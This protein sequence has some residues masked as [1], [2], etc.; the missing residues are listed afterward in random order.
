[1]DSTSIEHCEVCSKEFELRLHEVSTNLYTKTCPE[2][3]E[4]GTWF[5]AWLA[6][7]AAGYAYKMPE[8]KCQICDCEISETELVE[9]NPHHYLITCREHLKYARYF[10]LS[11][12]KKVAGVL[13]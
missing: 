6:K 5:H 13:V 7:K 10:D 8:P 12:A 3:A 11:A 4:Y 1:M 2:H 9:T